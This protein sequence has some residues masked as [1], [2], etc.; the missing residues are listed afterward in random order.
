MIHVDFTEPLENPQWMKWRKTADKRIEEIKKDFKAGND[1]KVTQSLYTR[2]RQ[3][4][5]DAFH[6][7]CAYCEAMLILDQHQGD[8]EHFRPKGSVTDQDDKPVMVPGPGGQ[9]M[10]HRGYPWLAYD[11]H[12][13]LPSCRAC[14]QPGTTRRGKRVG[15]WERFP[16]SGF[17]AT[18][19]EEVEREKPLLLHPID[20]EDIER[21]LGFRPKT[22][23]VFGKTRAGRMS[24]RVFDLNR[25]R[26]PEERKKVYFTVTLAAR[27]ATGDGPLE[28]RLVAKELLQ[29]YAEGREAYSWVGRL[30]MAAIEAPPPDA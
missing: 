6:G 16:V 4:F 5:L 17:R 7:K 23:F 26:L 19:P 15:K 20:V 27:A 11:W 21:H 12:N 28:E 3:V 10:P 13:L 22:G 8:V 1:I 2:M 14:N 25:E 9:L 18:L 29:S 24:V 30:A